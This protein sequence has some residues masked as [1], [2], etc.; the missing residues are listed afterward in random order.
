MSTSIETVLTPAQPSPSGL[1]V[2]ALVN[3][4]S[5]T[6]DRQ[7]REELQRELVAAFA[8]SGVTA[9]IAFLSG[10]ELGDA[11]VRAAESARAGTVDAVV[12]GG[13]DG[14]V[15]TVAGVLA[16]TGIPLGV[17]PLGTLNHFAKDLGIPPT[18]AGAVAVIAAAN[19]RPLDVAE[20]NGRVFVNNSSIGLYPFMV[21]DRERRR[22]HRG[23]TKWVA[24]F[25]AALRSLAYFPLHRL[26]ICAAGWT[27]PC[28]TPV[29]FVGNN[30]YAL[31]PPSFGRRETIDRGELWLCV[32]RPQSRVA[33]MWLAL[34][35][36][37]GF[38]PRGD[39]LRMFKVGSAEIVSRRKRL[40]VALDGEVEILK[41]PLRYSTRPGALRVFV[42][43]AQPAP[44]AGRG[45]ACDGP[46]AH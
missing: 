32:A 15:H 12:V 18:L 38:R 24:T 39:D 41:S 2:L 17:L 21:V 28:R 42:P 40:L 25:F 44:A 19:A 1:R 43:A 10:N 26:A 7:H 37:L 13:G 16:G 4:A 22:R 9:E 27:E 29:V 31:A 8:A 3:P 5:G 23:L 45:S 30:E 33:L 34:K 20:V 35:S 11:A 36:A 14:S 6:A 46:A